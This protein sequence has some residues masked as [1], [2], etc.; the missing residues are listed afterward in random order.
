MRLCLAVSPVRLRTT[1]LTIAAIGLF[2]TAFAA[3]ASADTEIPAE[4]RGDCAQVYLFREE[5]GPLTLD[6]SDTCPNVIVRDSDD[7]DIEDVDP[8]EELVDVEECLE[9]LEGET[10]LETKGDK[11]PPTVCIYPFGCR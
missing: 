1:L 11:F 7:C 4:D 10:V 9:D 3:P 8:T 5:V 2:A 6:G